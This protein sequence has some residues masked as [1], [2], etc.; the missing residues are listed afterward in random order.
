[1]PL[2]Y[3]EIVDLA[4]QEA[5]VPGFVTQTGFHLNMVLEDLALNY[6]FD[7]IVNETFTITTG[8]V[9]PPEGPYDLPPDYNRHVAE[10]VRF[11]FQGTP[12]NLYQK[13]LSDFKEYFVGPG[14]GNYPEFFSTDLSIPNQAKVF[15]WPPP[16]GSYVIEFPYYRKHT[17]EPSP[18][19]STNY[20]WFP[21]SSYLIKEV[22]ARLCSGND[23]DRAERLAFEAERYLTK[24]LKMKDDQEGYA[25]TVGLDR[26]NFPGRGKLRGTKQNPWSS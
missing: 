10:Q 5:K 24:Y 13:S 2:T 15:F 12:Y 19:T 6:D 21:M 26:N 16:N 18:E 8:T 14:I 1:M 25:Q 20:P 4:G 3:A 11:I 9:T 22:A 17:Y 7:L 23:D